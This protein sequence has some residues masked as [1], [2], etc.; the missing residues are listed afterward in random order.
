ME[1]KTG[2]VRDERLAQTGQLVAPGN[3]GIPRR[4]ATA[5]LG[6]GTWTWRTFEGASTTVNGGGVFARNDG[7]FLGS[8]SCV[9]IVG[10]V[11]TARKLGR[12][13]RV[14]TIACDGGGR[15]L[16]KFW[17]AEY[18]EKHGLTPTASGLEFLEET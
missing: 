4:R 12:G 10:A 9:N 2:A 7:L 14:V 13:H 17:S 1:S 15:H 3:R 6:R 5:G 18:L 11:K 8:S 16:S